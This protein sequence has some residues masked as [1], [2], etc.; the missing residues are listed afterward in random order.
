MRCLGCG[1]AARPEGSPGDRGAEGSRARTEPSGCWL[2]GHP[3]VP[4]SPRP[5]RPHPG[6]RHAAQVRTG[7]CPLPPGRCPAALPGPPPSAQPRHV[8]MTGSRTVLKPQ[9]PVKSLPDSSSS[10]AVH[11]LHRPCFPSRD[12]R[13]CEAEALPAGGGTPAVGTGGHCPAQKGSGGNG[14]AGPLPTCPMAPDPRGLARALG[15]QDGPALGKRAIAER[16]S[17]E[18]RGIP[19]RPS[20]RV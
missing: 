18:R 12:T 2:R 19:G 13:W 5:G 17:G 20:S 6:Q 1:E 4:A 7:L 16:G 14:S 8:G 11:L 15:G 10:P 9:L 3:A